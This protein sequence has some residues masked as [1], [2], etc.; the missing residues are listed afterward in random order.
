[1][2]IVDDLNF[3]FTTIHSIL[4]LKCQHL[5]LLNGK[6]A[7]LYIFTLVSV[8]TIILLVTYCGVRDRINKMLILYT[9]VCRRN[10]MATRNKNNIDLLDMIKTNNT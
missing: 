5:S 10:Q 7:R 8:K 2:K 6:N 1:M 9:R 3:F 4:R